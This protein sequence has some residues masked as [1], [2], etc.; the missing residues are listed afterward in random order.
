MCFI[1][2]VLQT[3]VDVKLLKWFAIIRFKGPPTR[4]FETYFFKKC[5]FLSEF[6]VG[7]AVVAA[8]HLLHNK[9]EVSY[10]LLV[11]VHSFGDILRRVPSNITGSL[12]EVDGKDND[13]ARK[14][15]SH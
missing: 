6:F 14:Q 2:A 1:D 4:L 9:V 3:T 5:L 8:F 13:D 10:R 15:W 11:I 12:S 7:V